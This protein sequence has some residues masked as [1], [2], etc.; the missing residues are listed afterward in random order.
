MKFDLYYFIMA[1]FLGC[2]IVYITHPQEKIIY[3]YQRDNNKFCTDNCAF[4]QF[5]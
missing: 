1:L 3:K 4:N 5:T 2:M